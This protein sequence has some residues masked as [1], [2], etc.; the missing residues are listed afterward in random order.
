LLL[1]ILNG[2]KEKGRRE[3]RKENSSGADA[4][5]DLFSIHSPFF[6]IAFFSSVWPKAE[7]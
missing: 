6:V 3:E 7:S 1:L 2:E 5:S 4:V